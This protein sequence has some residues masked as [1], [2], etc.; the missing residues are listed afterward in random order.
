MTVIWAGDRVLSE[1]AA[2][3]SSAAH[4]MPEMPFHLIKFIINGEIAVVPSGWY[5]DGMGFWPNYKS[6][7]R[8]KRA[9]L[10]G[11]QHDQN[12]PRYDVSVVRT[13]DNYKDAFKLTQQYG[14][15]YNTSDLE[16][17]AEN[18]E[19]PE[20]RKRKPVHRLGDSDD[21]E[22]DPGNGDLASLGLASQLHRQTAEVQILSLLE[23]NK[24]TQDQLMAKVNFLTSRLTSTPGPEVEMPANIQFSQE[25]LEAFEALL[26]TLT[27]LLSALTTTSVL[28]RLFPVISSLGTVGGQDVKRVTWNTLGR[29]FTDDV[30]HQLNWKGVS[31]KKAFSR[32]ATNTLLFSAD[33]ITGQ[34]QT[35]RTPN[36][37]SGGSTWRRIGQRGDKSTSTDRGIKIC[38]DKKNSY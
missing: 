33:L 2:Q 21:S 11:E 38:I 3:S 20:K 14:K 5:D 16:S 7:E 36:A 23:T 13:C 19:L 17:E 28:N 4:A 9:A 30:S 8:M 29:I 32:M 15:G 18:E 10:N 22:E 6:T 24:H 35:L 31:N 12:W 1:N 34:P 26:T 27:A 37:Q 25:Q